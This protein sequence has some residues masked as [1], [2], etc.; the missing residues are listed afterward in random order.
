[1]G[2]KRTS[3]TRSGS[4]GY[5]LVEVIV[6]TVILTLVLA[7]TFAVLRFGFDLAQDA[8]IETIASQILTAQVENLRMKPYSTVHSEYLSAGGPVTLPS[9][10]Q[11]GFTGLAT[12]FQVDASF[13]VVAPFGDGRPPYGAAEVE[14]SIRYT[15]AFQQEV[16]RTT[17]TRLSERGLSDYVVE[18]F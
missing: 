2:L 1:M 18:G 10:E 16:T 15:N 11:E 4:A 7:P 17:Y 5:S 12:H 3:R 13:N 9:L 14:V 8:R 6:G